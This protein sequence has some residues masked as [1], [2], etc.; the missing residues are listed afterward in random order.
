MAVAGV[1]FG[2]HTVTHPIVSR[3]S[4]DELEREIGDSRARIQ[5]ELRSDCPLFA[6]PNGSRADFGPREKQALRAAGYH[7]AVSLQGTLNRAR[8]DL[9]EIDRV[10][11]GRDLDPP[12]FDAA[13][14]GVLGW[15]RQARQGV[16]RLRKAVPA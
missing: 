7:A 11:V 6:Y 9:F 16:Q 13:V 3:I 4:L 12:M 1:E 15:A 8:P 10:N 14:S 2:S 5:A